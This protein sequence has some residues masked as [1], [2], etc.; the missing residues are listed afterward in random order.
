MMAIY[1]QSNQTQQVLVSARQK[2]LASHVPALLRMTA[3]LRLS[4]TALGTQGAYPQLMEALFR[5][6]KEW[7]KACEVLPDGVL[8]SSD[9]GIYWLLEPILQLH[10][11][12]LAMSVPSVDRS[13]S[14]AELLIQG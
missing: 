7:W 12:P 2:L 5:Y 3:F 6:D 10:T 8:C 11:H 4:C 14:S 9:P 13:L 1:S